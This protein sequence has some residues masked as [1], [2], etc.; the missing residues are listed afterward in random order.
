MANGEITLSGK[1][2]EMM[3]DPELRRSYLGLA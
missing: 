3:D 1:A 2:S